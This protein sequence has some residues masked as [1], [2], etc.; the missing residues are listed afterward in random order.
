MGRLAKLLSFTRVTREGANLSEVKI[1]PDGGSNITGEHFS[2]P[3]DD[4]YPLITDI[5][6]TSTNNRTGGES[7]IGYID[8]KNA[9]IAAE[10]DKRIYARDSGGNIVCALWLKND[11]TVDLS[12]DSDVKVTSGGAID[13]TSSGD[14]NINGVIIK[15]NGDVTMPNSLEV[16]GAEVKSHTHTQGPDS[17]GDTQVPT[18]PLI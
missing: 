4:S 9:G 6:I 2:A 11:G 15:A 10:G 12:S 1:D 16:A 14:V 18:G 17:A 7:V 3:G 5:V 13:L 8:V